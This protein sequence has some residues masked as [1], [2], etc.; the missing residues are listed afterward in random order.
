MVLGTGLVALF[1]AWG[2]ESLGRY[3]GPAEDSG[4]MFL[5]FVIIVVGAAGVAGLGR[6]VGGV[7]F[8][9]MISLR[10]TLA[11]IFALTMLEV[12]PL[13]GFFVFS[14]GLLIALGAAIVSGFGSKAVPSAEE[15]LRP[16]S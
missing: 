15:L 12:I 9:S 11:G 6:L 14:I 16:K 5:G 7:A 13:F 8:P 3:L 10:A 1:L 2:F 4:D